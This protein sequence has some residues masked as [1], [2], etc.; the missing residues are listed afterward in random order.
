MKFDV[1]YE[2]LPNHT[3]YERVEASSPKE[4]MDKLREM[5]NNNV[6]IKGAIKYEAPPG[7]EDAK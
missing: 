7:H 2:I 1:F 4:A 6:H 3:T 5:K